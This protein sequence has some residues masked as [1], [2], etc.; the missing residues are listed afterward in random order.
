MDAPARTIRLR[1]AYDGTRY[2]GWQFQPSRATVQGALAEAIRKVSGE[3]ILPKGSSRTDAGVHALDQVVAFQTTSR[4]APDVWVRALNAWLPADITVTEGDLAPDGFD[5]VSAP[6]SKRYRYRIYDAMP[7]PVFAK[8]FVWRWWGRLD[9]AAMQAAAPALVGEHDFTSF[10]STESTRLSKVRTIF[11][12]SVERTAVPGTG[13]G[14]EVW[15]EVEGNGFLYNMVRII[16]GSLVMVGAGRRSPGWLADALAA[17][18]RP[19]AGPTAPPQG[20][21]LIAIHLGHD[22][23]APSVADAKT[24]P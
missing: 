20:L 7:K 3:A 4:L 17:R 5:P 18:S 19:A 10:E 16:A 23:P 9:V 14:E 13:L 6:T 24:A 2:S 8:Q 12:L 11:S 1:L 15:I 21:C 22:P